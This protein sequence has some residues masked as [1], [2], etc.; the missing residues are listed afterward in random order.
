MEYIRGAG[1]RAPLAAAAFMVGALSLIGIPFTAGFAS[2]WFFA[3]AGL[4]Y[5]GPRMILVF[6]A[7]VI[8]TALNVIY[9][10]GAIIEIFRPAE[11]G[12]E[13][14]DKRVGPLRYVAL[15]GLAG[16]TV[17]LGCIPGHIIAW[18]TEG[19]SRFG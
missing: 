7:L 19:L 15:A 4:A 10:M 5:G 12:L 18:I 1:R 3:Q 14:P 8:S 17:L 2:K 16:L 9:F 11:D 6:T 13:R